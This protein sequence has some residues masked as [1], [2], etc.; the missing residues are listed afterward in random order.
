VPAGAAA[1]GGTPEP[2]A[3]DLERITPEDRRDWLRAIA[4][5]DRSDA[6]REQR[7]R[8]PGL[9]SDSFAREG[10]CCMT[11]WYSQ[12]GEERAVAKV[13]LRRSTVVEQWTGHQVGWEMA[14]GYEGDFGRSFNSPWV[15]VPLGLLFLAPF[16]DPRRPLRILHLDLLV[17]LGFGVSH[18]FFNAGEIGVSVPLVYPVLAYLLARM[19]WIGFRPGRGGGPLVPYAPAALL[20]VGVVV[21]FAARVALNV[22]DSNVVDVGY[23]GVIGA[24]HIAEGREL[25]DGRFAEDPP[26]ADTYGP[27][28]YLLYVPFL[29]LGWSG[30]WDDVP[31]AHGAAIA[32]DLL[33]IV[34]LFALGSRLGGRLLGAAL[35]FAWT[36]YPYALFPL[37]TNSNDALVGGLAILAVLAAGS[38]PARGALVGLGAAAKFAP[39]ALAPLFANPSGERDARRVLAFGAVLALVVVAAFVTFL[40]PGGLGDVYDRTLGFQLGRESPFSAWGLR[41][42]LEPLQVAVQLAAVNLAA[43]LLV[44]PA[45]KTAV[46]L[47]ALAAAVL[48]ALQLGSVHWFYLYVAWFAPLVLVA[49]LAR[50]A[51]A[52]EA[53]S[54]GSPEAQSSGM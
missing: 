20:L 28:N 2:P 10:D 37:M 41:P 35:A 34:A 51:E 44:A 4:V 40:P 33:V 7:E 48:I 15:L 52:P 18:L 42:S 9:R 25:Y 1:Q 14:R 49:L 39:L 19:L 30:E 32:F 23:A 27:V 22:A 17:L 16:V 11:V 6:V 29:T 47:A 8:Y 31:A 53:L 38:A 26:N 5:A 36:A 54:G 3:A 50:H 43:L 12:G 45:R 13:D 21:L 24:D 46:Q